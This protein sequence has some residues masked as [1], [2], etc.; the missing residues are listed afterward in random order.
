MQE[1]LLQFIWQFRYY[2]QR[3]LTL[4]NG[5]KLE[6][7]HPGAFNLHQGPDF[8][9]ARIRIDGLIWVGNVELHVRTS[10]WFA[11]AHHKDSLYKNV[12]L[13][14]VWHD[15]LNN[16]N[17]PIP[18]LT[19]QNL[20]PKVLLQQYEEWMLSRQ[21][22]PC[23]HQ[24][25]KVN[26]LV[27]ASWKDR[28]LVERLERKSGW[29]LDVFQ[30]SKQHW[31]ETCW[32][33]LARN[34]GLK[35]NADAFEAMARS[36][37]LNLIA[38]HRPHLMQIESLLL[39]QAGLLSTKLSLPYPSMLKK[40]YEFL[41]S[42]YSL[43]SIQLPVYFLR[44]RPPAFPTVRLAQ[45]SMLLH[46]TQQLFRQ[47]LESDSIQQLR[48]FLNVTASNEWDCYYTLEEVAPSR[49]K[50]MGEEFT[51]SLVLNTV[52][53]LVFTYGCWKKEQSYKD[54]AVQWLLQLPPEKNGI[55]NQFR[56]IGAAIGNAFESQ[57]LIE[58]KTQ[59]CDRKKCLDCAIG[60]HLISSH[61]PAS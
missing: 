45:L 16:P 29:M 25:Q 1:R 36:L 61:W 15:D 30:Q 34:F 35:V 6:V 4:S 41:K 56:L 10:D 54:K 19:L 5:S 52:I 18:V 2:N 50:H 3:Q 59:Y 22:I 8:Q 11:H 26:Y 40:E 57:A 60:N 48:M 33:L 46:R 7:L 28:L 53:P 21:F 47:L 31:E 49:I 9:Q 38:R 43:G 17:D 58:L 32:W 39:G 14:V 24:L 44:M 27:L 23:Q 55:T 20:V 42:K 12:I 37:P 13:H 51:D